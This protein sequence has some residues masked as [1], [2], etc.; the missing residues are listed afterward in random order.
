MSCPVF[1]PQLHG[2]HQHPEFRPHPHPRPP[3][4]HPFPPSPHLP[5]SH[6]PYIVPAPPPRR[7]RFSFAIHRL[8]HAVGRKRATRTTSSRARNGVVRRPRQRVSAP[9]AE[10]T[11]QGSPPASGAAEHRR[12]RRRPRVRS[13]PSRAASL[14]FLVAQNVRGDGS[15]SPPQATQQTLQLRRRRRGRH[16]R[17]ATRSRQPAVFDVD[18]AAGRT[19]RR[20]RLGQRR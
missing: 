3:L 15:S 14:Q 11:R 17:F 9:V 12:G 8:S 10:V 19:R 18:V 2:D 1:H 20:H 4:P 5:T 6:P 7:R 16:Q 13:V